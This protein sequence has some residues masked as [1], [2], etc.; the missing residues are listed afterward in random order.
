MPTPLEAL[1]AA[2]LF[3]ELPQPDLERL[4][5]ISEPVR[6]DPGDALIR[7]GE[8]GDAL[9]VVISGELDVVRGG[10]ADEV[11]LARVGPGSVQGEMALLEE[12]P[13]NATARAVT[14]VEA[15]RIP[16]PAMLELLATRPEA[17]LAIVRTTLARLRSTEALLAQRERLAS[18]GTLAAGLAHELNNPAAAIRRSVAGL[19]AEL[20]ARTAAAAE[21]SLADAP[22]LGRLVTARPAAAAAPRDAIE[23]SDRADELAER[24]RGLGASDPEE[25]AAALV[26]AGWTAD[27]V[28]GVLEPYRDGPID[29]AISWVSSV[30]TASALL[31]EVAMAAERMSEIVRAVKGYAYLDQA[32]V[33]RVDLRAGL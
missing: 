5:Q 21:L 22:R 9:Y 7:E 17:S 31:G 25:A 13:R 2:P 3:A 6:L 11:A 24:L 18:L 32:P 14:A 26:D 4:C 16:G 33:Q 15:L 12:R 27:D 30:A 20:A 28:A 10:G 19:E 8:P 23:R 29:A 1:R